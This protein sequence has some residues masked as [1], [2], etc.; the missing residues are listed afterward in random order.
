MLKD[1]RDVRK[2]L[3]FLDQDSSDRIDESSTKKVQK[4]RMKL[5][6]SFNNNEKLEENTGMGVEIDVSQNLN[7]SMAIDAAAGPSRC[8]ENPE[9]S[10]VYDIETEAESN[11]DENDEDVCNVTFTQFIES[12]RNEEDATFLANLETET[13]ESNNRVTIIPKFKPP[14]RERVL[15]TMEEYGIPK[16]RNEEPFFSDSTDVPKQKEVAHKILKVPGKGVEFLPQFVSSLEEVTGIGRW[17]KMWLNEFHPPLARTKEPT[18]KMAL[19]SAEK[20]LITPIALPPTQKQVKD[21]MR[22]RDYLNKKKVVSED[23]KIEAKERAVTEVQNKVDHD[24]NFVSSPHSTDS[25][26]I[27]PSPERTLVSEDLTKSGNTTLKSKLAKR[28]LLRKSLINRDTGFQELNDSKEKSLRNSPDTQPNPSLL[29]VLQ[30]SRLFRDQEASRHLGV[31]CGQIEFLSDSTRSNI[32]N[33][34]LQR[35]KALIKVGFQIF[36]R[37]NESYQLL[38]QQ[39]QYLKNQ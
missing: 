27:E 16:F 13:E 11:E 20:V 6:D 19:A 26:V 29:D 1:G 2:K 7:D 12:Q 34:N 14:S 17:R 4:E 39:Y 32:T 15:E 22:A 36:F 3:L 31:S 8:A 28:G 21:W 5:R 9:S 38:Q 30:K 37:I 24:E 25:S 18:V 33:E 35:A 23:R 10:W